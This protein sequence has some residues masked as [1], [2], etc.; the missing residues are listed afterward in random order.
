LL[1]LVAALV[2]RD[3]ES[4][5][6]EHDVSARLLGHRERKAAR[7]FGSRSHGAEL[8]SRRTTREWPA[9]HVRRLGRGRARARGAHDRSATRP[10]SL[11]H[12][13]SG[14]HRTWTFSQRRPSSGRTSTD[15]FVGSGF[16]PGRS[17][18]RGRAPRG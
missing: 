1:H 16:V 15:V 17:H 3:R 12:A 18:R 11:A 14:S 7:G 8:R 2:R 6:L 13:T 10:S 5:R 4:P 9:H